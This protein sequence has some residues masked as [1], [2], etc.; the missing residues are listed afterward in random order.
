MQRGYP[1]RSDSDLTAP[2]RDC[3][4]LT[5]RYI[6]SN[7]P[8]KSTQDFYFPSRFT[9]ISPLPPKSSQPPASPKP[10]T[11]PDT[12]SPFS[13]PSQSASVSPASAS[14]SSVR[15]SSSSSEALSSVNESQQEWEA[16]NEAN[17]P[18][19]FDPDTESEEAV[20]I[21][22]KDVDYN[23]PCWLTK[24]SKPMLRR[25]HDDEAVFEMSSPSCVEIVG[26][27]DATFREAL[28]SLEGMM[29]PRARGRPT[30]FAQERVRHIKRMRATLQREMS[31]LKSNGK[32]AISSNSTQRISPV[33]RRRSSSSRTGSRPH[34]GVHEGTNRA[35]E[36]DKDPDAPITLETKDM[37]V[38]GCENETENDLS[39]SKRMKPH[40]AKEKTNCT[41]VNRRKNIE[42]GRE[43]RSY[44]PDE[45][46]EGEIQS[47]FPGNA[48]TNRK[49]RKW[50]SL[51]P[52]TCMPNGS[53][54]KGETTMS[55]ETMPNRRDGKGCKSEYTVYDGESLA[56]RD[57][58][59]SKIK[60]PVKSVPTG[61]KGILVVPPKSNTGRSE[62][63]SRQPKRSHMRKKKKRKHE[64]MNRSDRNI[65]IKIKTDVEDNAAVSFQKDV[66]PEGLPVKNGNLDFNIDGKNSA[67][68]NDEHKG[69]QSLH[70][71]NSVLRSRIEELNGKLKRSNNGTGIDRIGVEEDT[72]ASLLDKN[73]ALKNEVA[74]LKERLK[75]HEDGTEIEPTNSNGEFICSMRQENKENENEALRKKVIKLSKRLEAECD[76]ALE[77]EAAFD[78]VPK[79]EELASQADFDK[80]R[81]KVGE[82]EV[83]AAERENERAREAEEREALIAEKEAASRGFLIQISGLDDRVSEKQSRICYLT[84]EAD[85]TDAAI[86][87]ALKQ[88]VVLESLV[89]EKDN[90]IRCLRKTIEEHAATLQQLSMTNSILQS[91]AHALKAL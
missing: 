17:R 59:E 46:Q 66:P 74:G 29:P 53:E 41:P 68:M 45:K 56:G 81:Q 76:R 91:K 26:S 85:H 64:P 71:L 8:K 48:P 79:A 40:N 69:M 62:T 87:N 49:K 50:L 3:A 63:Q 73:E 52:K 18:P 5:H 15:N 20:D 51:G 44:V 36:K 32:Q 24:T 83:D 7:L 33:L 4:P 14:H 86:S 43:S 34:R 72:T 77:L 61:T 1:L 55:G 38:I 54:K 16:C 11:N 89:E 88:I 2:P 90:E 22:E 70:E 42:E 37:S 10:Q 9:S 35:A 78:K 65:V 67:R 58:S 75:Q 21:D 47:T 31:S 12:P 39:V 28:D 84:A 57:G 13:T 80:M 23:P 82:L 25:R 19:S 60:N 30:N 6:P 27:S